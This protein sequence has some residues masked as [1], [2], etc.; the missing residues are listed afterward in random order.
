MKGLSQY[1]FN[2]EYFKKQ[3]L[4]LSYFVC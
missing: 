2:T 1:K 3:L 4:K